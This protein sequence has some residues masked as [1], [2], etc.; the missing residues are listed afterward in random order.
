MD[1]RLQREIEFHDA[2]YSKDRETRDSDRFYAIN[3]ASDRYFRDAIDALAPGSKMLDY[4][5][6]EGGYAAL[7]AAQAGHDVVAIDISPVAI[8]NAREEA[9]KLGVAEQI[10]FRVMNAEDLDSESDAFDLV[11]GLGVLH[12]LDLA[13]A[14]KEIARVTKPSGAGVFVEPLGHNPVINLHRNRTPEQRT[15]DEHPLL[16]SDFDILKSGFAAIDV[17]YFHLLGL[18]ALPFTERPSFP[19]LLARLDA[20]DRVLFRTPLRRW[21]WSAGIRLTGPL[22]A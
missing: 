2:R 16:M 12:H 18:L 6:G 3:A 5:C 9:D 4:G 11:C 10:D 21:A 20:M 8:E 22:P 7:H 14:V 17:E 19:K 13:V 15:P 1:D